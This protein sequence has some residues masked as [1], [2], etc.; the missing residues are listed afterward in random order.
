[1]NYFTGNDRSKWRSNIATYGAVTYENIYKDIDIKFYGNNE[2]IEHD[3]IVHPGGDIAE[4][5][6]AYEGINGLKVTEAGDLEVSLKE[7]KIIEQ[8]PLIYQEIDGERVAVEGVYRI[9]KG[10]EGAFGYGFD[11]ASYDHTKDLVVDPVLVYSTYL[12]GNGNDIAWSIAVDSSSN[13]YVMGYTFSTN[14]PL[15]NPAQ[16]TFGGTSDIFVTKI[17]PAGTALVYSTYLGGSGGEVGR[18]IAVDSAGNAYVAGETRSLNFPLMNPL[19]GTFGGG[20]N[21]A[22]ITK[23]NPAGSA[24]VYS[25][26]IGGSV[27]EEFLDIALDASRNAYVTGYT[28]S[29]DYPLMNP[30]QA[31]RGGGYS[32]AFVT[33]INP[34]GSALVYSTYLGGSGNEKGWGIAADPSG[35]AYVTGETFSPDFPLSGAMQVALQGTADAFVTRINPAGTALVYSTYLGG[36]GD[37]RGYGIAFDNTGAAYVTGTTTSPNFP[38]VAPI[39]GTIGGYYDAF[40]TKIN[41]AGTALVYATYL[42]GSNYDDGMSI[43]VDSTGSAYV[44]G[45]AFSWNFPLLNPIQGAYGGGYSDVYVAQIT[46]TGTALVYSTYLGGSGADY[47]LDI[48]VDAS[49]NAYVTGQIYS[50]NFPLMT[51]VQG[52]FGGG[53]YDGFVAKIGPSNHPPLADAGADQNIFL[54]ETAYLDGSASSDPDGDTIVSYTW[55]IDSAPMGSTATLTGAASV[56]PSLTPDIAGQYMISLIVNDG[57]A[58]SASSTVSVT[59]TENMPPVAVATG[60]PLTGYFPLGVNLNASGSSD[61]EGGALSFFWDFGDNATATGVAPSHTYATVGTYTAVVTVTDDFGNTNQASVEIIV[62]APNQPPTV[63]PTAS[64]YNGTAPLDVQFT[65]NGLDPEGGVLTY[66][67]D[68]GDG[69]NSTAANPLHT[70]T[71]PGTYV[72]AVTV[73]DGEF[74]ASGSVTISVGSPLACNVTEAK[75]DEGKKGKVEGKVDVKAHFTY[76]GMPAPSE[77]IEVIFDN[78]T[79]ISEPFIAFTEEQDEPGEFKFKDKDLHMKIDF[80]KKIIKVSRHK[81]VLGEVDNS[82]GVDVVI[83]FGNAACT[84]HVVMEEHEDKD[85]KKKMSHKEKD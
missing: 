39:Q 32:E 53:S 65:A 22:F 36:S 48:A 47:G 18:G 46:S 54:T 8:R 30:L 27:Y 21:D 5:K 15:L 49:G 80:T 64:T 66:S 20:T 83:Y 74:T 1:V 9:L 57:Q 45:S 26:Y 42:G 56:S 3:V 10:E 59:A 13:A 63:G 14:F 73:S 82:N 7:G 31:M 33:K 51:P 25:T 43:A 79:L 71:S 24:L 44:A 35:S 12:G 85:H 38:L 60:T 41:P 4:V 34:A 6:F 62:S 17:N 77:L 37:D 72:A 11:V 84:D 52:A 23:I 50:R 2:N 58:N 40:V 76:T 28:T 16:G 70:Y 78:I 29:P 69:T 19:Q 68:F 75:A 55:T 67:W 81:M 61:P